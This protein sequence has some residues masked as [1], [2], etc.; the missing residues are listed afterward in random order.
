MKKF[1]LLSLIISSAAFAAFK[2]GTYTKNVSKPKK[3][4]VWTSEISI[5]VKDGKI[6]DAILTN[7]NDKGVDKAKDVEYNQKWMAASNIDFN[8]F[9]KKFAESLIATQDPDKI[10]TIVGATHATQQYKELAKEALKE[11]KASCCQ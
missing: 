9:T 3:D 10:D 11:A 1:L 8:L 6:V 7:K 2:D 5:V 4:I